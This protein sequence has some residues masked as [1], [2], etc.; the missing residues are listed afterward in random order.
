MMMTAMDELCF[1]M[2]FSNSN[3][4]GLPSGIS[5]AISAKSGDPGSWG[6][7]NFENGGIFT[8]GMD[9]GDER[10]WKTVSFDEWRKEFTG[11]LNM[12]RYQFGAGS[13]AN[14]AIALIPAP[15]RAPKPATAAAVPPPPPAELR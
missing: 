8:N 11:A 12:L 2:R 7:I 1:L 5:T 14:C 4:A 15:P 9:G 3:P 6:G 10:P 13:T